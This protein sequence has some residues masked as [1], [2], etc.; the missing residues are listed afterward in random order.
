MAKIAFQ[1]KTYNRDGKASQVAM[2]A[3]NIS[4]DLARQL[5]D[6]L[7]KA[8]PSPYEWKRMGNNHPDMVILDDK[9]NDIA[10]IRLQPY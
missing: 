1:V 8:C 2:L 10:G 9:M 3:A 4:E 7:N 5:A 6:E